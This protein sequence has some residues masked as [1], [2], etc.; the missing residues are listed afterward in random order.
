[1]NESRIDPRA[2]A[3]TG[4]GTEAGT[5][6]GTGAGTEAGTEE[7]ARGTERPIPHPEILLDALI[8]AAQEAAREGLVVSTSGNFS[9]R[10]DGD[11]IAISAARTRLGTLGREDLVV[12]PIEGV[13]SGGVATARPDGVAPRPSRETPMHLA[14]HA[15]YPGRISSVLHFQSPAATALACR[16]GTLPDLSFL[17]E[18]PVYVRRVGD[19]PYLPPG[20]PELARAVVDAFRD[21]DVR[22]AQLRNHGQVV[23]AE[24][25]AEA[26]ERATFFELAAR[27]FL[28]AGEGGGLR[29]FSE[30]EL[31]RLLAY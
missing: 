4:A 30:E 26:V 18:I 29:R 31:R 10:L 11:R 15:A 8:A 2:G 24:S 27:I 12:L 3:R 1:M 13:A 9:V 16:Q 19:V 6:A 7:G 28:L 22:L 14:L 21:P 5:E 23:V 25:P 17:P 20:S